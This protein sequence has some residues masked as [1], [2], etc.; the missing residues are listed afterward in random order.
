MINSL[1]Y[2]LSFLWSFIS[3]V[4]MKCKKCTAV[5]VE[6]E[7]IEWFRMASDRDE[8]VRSTKDHHPRVKVFRINSEF[9]I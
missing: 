9:R 8:G 3:E 7:C 2:L 4:V 5:E 6:L 1:F